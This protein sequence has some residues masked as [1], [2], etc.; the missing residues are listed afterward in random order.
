MRARW[1]VANAVPLSALLAMVQAHDAEDGGGLLTTVI[2]T[3]ENP[4]PGAVDA[5]ETAAAAEGIMLVRLG[6][7]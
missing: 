1:E 2:F 3:M 6:D 5:V 7:Q 4:T